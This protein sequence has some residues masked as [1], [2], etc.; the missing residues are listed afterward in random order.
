MAG[1]DGL[2]GESVRT[3]TTC[4]AFGEILPRRMEPNFAHPTSDGHFIWAQ[5]S[6]FSSEIIVSQKWFAVD[7]STSSSKYSTFG[8]PFTC[9]LPI[10]SVLCVLKGKR[11]GARVQRLHCS[12]QRTWTVDNRRATSRVARMQSSRVLVNVAG[13]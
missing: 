13:F 6:Q 11:P 8:A 12:C 2:R 10:L 3:P 4:L 7:Q 9:T 5:L 1:V